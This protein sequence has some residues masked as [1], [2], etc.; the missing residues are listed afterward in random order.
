M[1]TTIPTS[2]SPCISDSHMVDIAF[3]HDSYMTTVECNSARAPVPC[4]ETA[5]E[6]SGTSENHQDEC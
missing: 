4:G 3:T 5:V 1:G 6:I 2:G